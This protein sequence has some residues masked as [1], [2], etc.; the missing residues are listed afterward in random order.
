MKFLKTKLLVTALIL[1]AATSAF[2]S[3]TYDVAVNTSGFSGTSGYL[4]LQYD[5]QGGASPSTAT[6][7]A[8]YPSGILG[9]QD[10]VDVVNG[11]AV[12][13]T[14]PG[15]VVFANTNPVNDYNQ[16]ITFGPGFRFVLSFSPPAPGGTSGSV[17]TFSLGLFKD[18]LGNI[19]LVNP[20]GSYAGTAFTINLNN[21]STT[22]FSVMAP[23]ASVP[24]PAALWL[25]GPGLAGLAGIRKRVKK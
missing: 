18:N 7:S 23:Q 8:F 5:P 22:S 6:V 17:S 4:Y 13:G 11:S 19:A 24:L 15:T 21:D 1:F 20:T 25:L 10:T 14:L 9:P 2:A 12:T 16:A 3:L